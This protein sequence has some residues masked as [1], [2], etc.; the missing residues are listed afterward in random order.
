MNKNI[1]TLGNTENFSFYLRNYLEYLCENDYPVF[2]NQYVSNILTNIQNKSYDNYREITEKEGEEI[3][4]AAKRYL[5]WAVEYI[6]GSEIF[7]SEIKE[8]VENWGDFNDRYKLNYWPESESEFPSEKNGGKG[9][10]VPYVKGGI[11][12]PRTFWKKMQ[13]SEYSRTVFGK[14]TG[15]NNYHITTGNV[16]SSYRT[17]MPGIGKDNFKYAGTTFVIKSMSFQLNPAYSPSK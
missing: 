16:L 3:A 9:N 10:P 8:G 12:T 1:P 17:F 13:L 2:G 5:N 6:L 15:Y 4:S 7:D 11:D 14:E